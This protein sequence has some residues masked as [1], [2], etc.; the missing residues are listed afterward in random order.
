MSPVRLQTL[1]P[2]TSHLEFEQCEG[3]IIVTLA[4][5]GTEINFCGCI[6]QKDGDDYDSDEEIIRQMKEENED[7]FVM[8]WNDIDQEKLNHK[9]WLEDEMDNEKIRKSLETMFKK[10]KEN[11][12]EISKC[13]LLES[14]QLIINQV[15]G[16]E[17]ITVIEDLVKEYGSDPELSQ[18]IASMKQQVKG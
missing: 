14:V 8:P 5:K 16:Q 15:H 13:L 6:L 9:L 7:I 1:L 18:I 4:K 12:L 3:K 2:E 17:C 10:N 11:A